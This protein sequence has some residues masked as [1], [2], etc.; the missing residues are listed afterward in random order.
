MEKILFIQNTILHYRKGFYNA[1][2]LKYQVIVLHS[3]EPTVNKNDNYSEIILPCNKLGYFFSQKDLVSSVKHQNSDYVIAMFDIRWLN[4]FRLLGKKKKYKF[5]W[6]GLDTGNN[7]LATKIKVLIARLGY[8]IVFYNEYNKNKMAALN[9]GSSK[10]FV[11]NNTFDV[12]T[13]IKSYEN[14]I[15]NKILF[16]GSFDYRKRNDLLV[17][18]FFQMI[19]Q[20]PKDIK[21]IF[22]GDGI[23]KEKI[24]QLVSKLEL[25]ERVEFVG[26][27]DD[28][29]KLSDFYL[30]AIFTVSY[31]QAGLSVLQSLGFGVPYL[32]KKN[33][34]SGGE[35]SN[36]EHGVNG[37]LCK[38]D[39]ESLREYMLKLI[40]DIELSRS[41][42]AN[43]Y[44]YYSKE[45]TV[46]NMADSFC[47]ALES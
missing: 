35:I 41:L 4:T 11:A 2:A 9:L 6:W 19:T 31:G 40:L 28:P 25:S 36:I 45:C 3:G 47:S 42:G 39:I 46:Q 26:R 12:G 32:T 15:K 43:A 8:P 7:Q 38:D 24:E 23:E 44:E 5:L 34:I 10:L 37:Y 29:K 21:L 20:I 13:R 18:A 22:V 1:L 17:I 27:V 14:P 33:A 16:V 30:E